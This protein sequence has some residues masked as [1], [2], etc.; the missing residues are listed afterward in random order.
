MALSI[1]GPMAS[2][3]PGQGHDVDRLPGVSRQ[4]MPTSTDS[5]KVTM[6]MMVMR[7]CPRNSRIT[8]EQRIGPDGPFL[9]QGGHR[10]PDVD[11]LVHDHLEVDARRS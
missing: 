9:H 1:M 6:A 10:G 8:S 3:K 4:M 5:G 11:R 7:H 2:V